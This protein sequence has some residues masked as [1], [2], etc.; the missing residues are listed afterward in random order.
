MPCPQGTVGFTLPP[1]YGGVP[2]YFTQH[3]PPT[4]QPKFQQMPQQNPKQDPQN[5][6]ANENCL[7]VNS[8]KK[9]RKQKGD[10]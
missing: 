10:K 8:T 5:S 3:Q 1:A 7:N 9:G 4:P 2:Q 6:I